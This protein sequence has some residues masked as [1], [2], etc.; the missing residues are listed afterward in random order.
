MK[1]NH[2]KPRYP[3]SQANGAG[4]G[5]AEETIHAVVKND[6]RYSSGVRLPATRSCFPSNRNEN[7]FGVKMD[8]KSL[9]AH[10]SHKDLRR[11][12]VSP[13]LSA[14]EQ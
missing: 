5:A 4:F 10:Q 7:S 3:I 9:V 2:F 14:C 11:N 13:Y 12:L 1:V 6:K 8:A